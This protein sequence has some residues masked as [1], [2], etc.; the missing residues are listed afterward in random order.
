MRV[1]R[2]WPGWAAGWTLVV[3]AVIWV[4]VSRD[5]WQERTEPTLEPMEVASWV[6]TLSYVVAP[7]VVAGLVLVVA[8]LRA[9]V[10]R[11]LG[12]AIGGLGMLV[13]AVALTGFPDGVLG[14]WTIGLTALGGALALVSAVLAPASSPPDAPPTLL[15]GLALVAAGLL[16]GWTCWRGG[17][18]W[19]WRGESAAGY[20]FGLVVAVLLVVLGLTLHRWVA[21]RVPVL[22]W[23]L[24][25]VGTLGL[26]YFFAGASAMVEGAGVLYRWEEDE[27]PWDYGMLFLLLGAGVAATGVAAWR[28][29]GDL[30]AWSLASGIS[31]M[32]ISLWQQSTWG[33]VMR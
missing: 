27:S 29:R 17:S 30:V 21:L 6:P 8:G 19:D 9:P 32:W 15:P 13:G 20:G 28:R 14:A 23:V 4:A 10:P 1:L 12:L 25:V 33:S 31:F 5:A 3:Q 11:R 22:R 24:I 26:P 18:Y 16:T 2:D 7:A